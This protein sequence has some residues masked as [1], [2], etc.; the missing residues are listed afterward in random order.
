MVSAALRRALDTGLVGDNAIFHS[1]RGSQYSAAHTRELLARH[2]LR[3]SMSAAG[4]CYDNAFAESA[5]ASLKAELP[6]DGRP[7]DSKQA[8]TTAVFDYL[9]TFYNKRRRHS[10]LGY[11]SPQA[12]LH[13]YFQTQNPSLN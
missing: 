11:Q 4:Y 9:E 12:F 2:G 1:D 6:G 3:Q 13:Q 5:F 7:F 8:A 10:A